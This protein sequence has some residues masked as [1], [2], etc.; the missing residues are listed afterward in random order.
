M[1]IFVRGFAPVGAQTFV[2]A[3]GASWPVVLERLGARSASCVRPILLASRD[4]VSQLSPR[5]LNFRAADICCKLIASADG[6]A[7]SVPIGRVALAEGRVFPFSA[8][9]VII[10]KQLATSPESVFFRASL[11][12]LTRKPSLWMWLSS[13]TRMGTR[14]SSILI[15]RG[16]RSSL[17][18]SRRRRL[19]R[20]LCDPRW[21]GQ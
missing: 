8:S 16:C 4:N 7:L 3:N 5:F 15:R 18:G 9:W 12:P 17:S 19:R 14:P 1:A 2:V 11:P 13:D 21:I 10:R 6:L 20:L